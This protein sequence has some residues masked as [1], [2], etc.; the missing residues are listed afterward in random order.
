MD[1]TSTERFVRLLTGNQEKLYA[2][3]RSLVFDANAARDILQD[4]NL[5]LWRKASEFRSGTDFMLWACRVARYQVMAHLRDAR[6]DRHVFEDDL[7]DE[8][9]DEAQRRVE[10]VDRRRE[11]L[12]VCLQKLTEEQRQMIQ[13]RYSDISVAEIAQ[14]VGRTPNHVYQLLFRIRHMLMRCV[15]KQLQAGDNS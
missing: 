12:R 8:L 13:R 7:L 4:T 1:H 2:F 15:Q 14:M 11:A 9:A 3:V 6:R 10:S 5:V